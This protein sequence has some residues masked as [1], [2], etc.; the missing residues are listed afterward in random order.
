MLHDLRYALQTLPA[1]AVPAAMSL[2]S[3]AP[4]TGAN[5]AIYSVLDAI[6]VRTL[7]IRDSQSIVVMQW[8][9]E[10]RV[11]VAKSINGSMWK[12]DQLVS[13]SR[14]LP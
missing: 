10:E 7:P 3:L 11:A 1:N 14:D 5:P 13:I 2:L 6:L 9:A 8:H 12:D 4:G